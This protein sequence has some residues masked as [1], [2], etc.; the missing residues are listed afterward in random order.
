LGSFWTFLAF[1]GLFFSYMGFLSSILRIFVLYHPIH[2][3]ALSIWVLLTFLDLFWTL[4]SF[5]GHFG[6]L[7]YYV[8]GS[9]TDDKA[10]VSGIH[11]NPPSSCEE[12][13]FIRFGEYTLAP[14]I[15]LCC[16]VQQRVFD[17]YVPNT[18]R[19]S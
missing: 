18:S 7:S 17:M 2:H 15:E 8:V 5:L 13:L 3:E 4:C 14:V 19:I 11:L 9:P 12:D 6:L 10:R 1:L 16:S